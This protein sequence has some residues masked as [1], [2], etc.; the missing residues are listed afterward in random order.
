MC[1]PIS[2]TIYAA[3][4]RLTHPACDP[5]KAALDEVDAIYRGE[6]PALTMDTLFD[7][8]HGSTR[9]RAPFPA[10]ELLPSDILMQDSSPEP[11]SGA[12]SAG[13]REGAPHICR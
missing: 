4:S 3:V 7:A 8:R 6:P 10:T 1:T 2:L 13:Q 12:T 11:Q 5:G 9:R